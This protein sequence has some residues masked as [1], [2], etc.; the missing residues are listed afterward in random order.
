LDAGYSLQVKEFY[1]NIGTILTYAVVGTIFNTVA[2]G[3]SIVISSNCFRLGLTLTLF[4]GL[5]ANQPSIINLFQFATLISA[6]DP[7]AVICVFDELQ[8]NRILHICVPLS[9][10]PYTF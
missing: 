3:W 2:I 9:L 10:I 8:V 1:H 6:V 4:R 5:F 7:V